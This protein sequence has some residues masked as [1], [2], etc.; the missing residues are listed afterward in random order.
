M[1]SGSKGHCFNQTQTKMKVNWP[2]LNNTSVKD[3]L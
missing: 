2:A 1:D 3:I